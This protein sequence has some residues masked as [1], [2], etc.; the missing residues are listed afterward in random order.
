VVLLLKGVAYNGSSA[1]RWG[2]CRS[3]KFPIATIFNGAA[4]IGNTLVLRIRENQ[5]GEFYQGDFHEAGYVQ[6]LHT[7]LPESAWAI[8]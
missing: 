5:F 1:G 6:T 7:L 8:S 3:Q 2:N 4:S